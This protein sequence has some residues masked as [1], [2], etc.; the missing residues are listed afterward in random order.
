MYRPNTLGMTQSTTQVPGKPTWTNGCAER[1]QDDAGRDADDDVRLCLMCDQFYTTQCAQR[2][3]RVR[4]AFQNNALSSGPRPRALE[5]TKER[6][7]TS[8]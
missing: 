5:T 8:L 6:A 3:V 4:T 7:I 2:E 1:W